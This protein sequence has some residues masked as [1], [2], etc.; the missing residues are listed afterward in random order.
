MNDSARKSIVNGEEV[1]Y[2]LKSQDS[3]TKAL[4]NGVDKRINEQLALHSQTFNHQFE[5]LQDG[6]CERHALF[7]KLVTTSKISIELKIKEFHDMFSTEFNKLDK[8]CENVKDKVGVLIGATRTMIEEICDFNKDYV[9]SLNEKIEKDGK[10]FNNIE[11]SLNGFQET[12]AKLDL[13]SK[14]LFS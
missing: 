2:L 14:T 8:F 7:E 10:V 9:D 11:I 4:I 6:A 1:E 12:F 13:S 3:R 5:K